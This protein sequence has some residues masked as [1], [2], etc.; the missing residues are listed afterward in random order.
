MTGGLIAATLVD[1]PGASEVFRGGFVTYQT[2]AK[3]VLLDIPQD[4]ISR[5]N[6]VSAEVAR[7]MARSTQAKTGADFAIATTGLAGPSGGTDEIPIGT[8]YVGIATSGHCYA[9]PLR[10]SGERND[11]RRTTVTCALQFLLREALNVCIAIETTQG[12]KEGTSNG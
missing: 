6:V 5:F 10:L 4:I 9:L 7:D 2:E 3:T 1:V 12:E 11:I 8:V